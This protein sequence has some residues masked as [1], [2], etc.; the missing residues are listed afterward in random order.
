[1]K[2]DTQVRLTNFLKLWWIFQLGYICNHSGCLWEWEGL[3]VRCGEKLTFYAVSF[4][5]FFS[6]IFSLMYVFHFWNRTSYFFKSV[7]PKANLEHRPAATCQFP[8][9]SPGSRPLTACS[10]SGNVLEYRRRVRYIYRLCRVGG[11]NSICDTD[12]YIRWLVVY[13]TP[14]P[15][16]VRHYEWLP[17]LLTFK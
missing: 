10:A 9:F 6:P 15:P 4:Y 16:P 14:Q 1:M 8:Q 17:N 3:G 11:C 7:S 13:I 2:T 5:V 12:E